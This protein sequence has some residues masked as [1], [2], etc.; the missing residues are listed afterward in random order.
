MPSIDWTKVLETAIST[1]IVVLVP[2]LAAWLTGLFASWR[3]KLA[4]EAD[5]AWYEMA[6]KEAAVAVLATFQGLVD[7]FKAASKDGK[8]TEDERAAALQHAM[9]IAKTNIGAIPAHIR[10][11][12]EHWLRGQVEAAVAKFKLTKAA[13]QPTQLPTSGGVQAVAPADLQTR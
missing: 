3:S 9:D 10:P 2:L 11:K 12:F 1:A 5:D 4:I 7:D 8:L 6:G 13:Q